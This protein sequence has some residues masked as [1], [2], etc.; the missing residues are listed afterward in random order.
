MR[1]T[2]GGCPWWLMTSAWASPLCACP[3]WCNYLGHFKKEED[4]FCGKSISAVLRTAAFPW[5][6]LSQGPSKVWILPLR[7]LNIF[8]I[9]HFY[10]RV[11]SP[12]ILSHLYHFSALRSLPDMHLSSHSWVSS[13]TS[14]PSLPFT[15]QIFLWL[16]AAPSAIQLTLSVLLPSCCYA[17]LPSCL[18][19]LPPSKFFKGILFRLT[20]SQVFLKMFLFSAWS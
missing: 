7:Y 15:T 4:R 14:P 16:K 12:G 20:E 17:E 19:R 8:L 3:F 18:C 11:S 9:F 6:E 1:R 13:T 10:W 2:S 5:S